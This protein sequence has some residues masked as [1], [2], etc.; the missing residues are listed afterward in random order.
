MSALGHKRTLTDFRVMSALPLKADIETL[1]GK[2]NRRRGKL[3]AP[4][5][6]H[7]RVGDNG[8]V[9]SHSARAT[10]AGSSPRFCHHP[11]SSL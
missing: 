11:A 4:E 10:L 8:C 5:R 1:V 2:G 3:N 9:F 6:R 7:Q